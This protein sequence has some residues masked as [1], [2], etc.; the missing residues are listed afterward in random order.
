MHKMR[1]DDLQFVHEVAEHGSLSAAA[2][3]LG[4]NHATVLRRISALEDRFGIKLFERPPGGYRMTP[5]GREILSALQVIDRT[6]NGVERALPVVGRGLHGRVRVTTTD[7]LADLILPRHL[8]SLKKRH[9]DLEVELVVSNAPVSIDH[10]QAEI[11]V[12]PTRMLP[13]DLVGHHAAEMRFSVY[14]HRNDLGSFSA[15]AEDHRWVGVAPP[16]T[17]SPVGAWQDRTIGPFLTMRADS[18]LTMAR[19]V[20]AGM[21]LA[22]LPDFVAKAHPDLVQVLQYE[23]RLVTS[24]WVAAHADLTHAEPVRI[25]L[26]DLTAALSKDPRLQH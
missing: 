26:D 2:R 20:E 10:A 23:E 15:R 6:V 17:R 19:L 5:E 9:A 8:V 21:G 25:L 18:F 7:S 22:M 24:V 16:L 12:R 4:V 11:T 1:W 13:P 14:G 3:S